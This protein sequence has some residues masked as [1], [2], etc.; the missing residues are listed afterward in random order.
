[1]PGASANFSG[2]RA[3]PPTKGHPQ[4]Y[5]PC[6]GRLRIHFA[7]YQCLR[8]KQ[9]IKYTFYNWAELNSSCLGRARGFWMHALA[10]ARRS[11]ST[12]SLRCGTLSPHKKTGTR[13]APTRTERR[14]LTLFVSFPRGG[15]KSTSRAQI[16]KINGPAPY[17]GSNT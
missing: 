9:T 17:S 16:L 15:R 7:F 8:L 14:A 13:R 11:N 2:L 1:M 4:V 10:L 3:M 5:H 6:W 12:W